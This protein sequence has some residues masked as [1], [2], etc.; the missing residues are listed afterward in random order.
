MFSVTVILMSFSLNNEKNTQKYVGHNYYLVNYNFLFYFK[1]FCKSPFVHQFH[2][3]K[4]S[5]ITEISGFIHLF[6]L[7]V[8]IRQT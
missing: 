4:G 7:I 5:D 6:L 1:S 2:C 8:I 3:V